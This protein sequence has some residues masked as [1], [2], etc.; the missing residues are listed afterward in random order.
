MVKG[1]SITLHGNVTGGM[2][3][4][5][6]ID[7]MTF[8]GTPDQQTL[9]SISNLP[10]RTHSVSITANPPDGSSNATLLFESATV[11]VGTGLTG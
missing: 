7:G 10:L 2:A 5:V 3:F 8:A 6:D 4:D 11:T 1:Q 9:V